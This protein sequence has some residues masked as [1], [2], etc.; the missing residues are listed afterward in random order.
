MRI[1][2]FLVTAG[3][4]AVFGSPVFAQQANPLADV[5]GTAQKLMQQA[6]PLNLQRPT[7]TPERPQG[8]Q[9]ATQPAQNAAGS[10]IIQ[11]TGPNDSR[12]S[13]G[14]FR[15]PYG[16]DVKPFDIR[17][18]SL[19]VSE[20]AVS[21][22]F[23]AETDAA[24]EQR[25]RLSGSNLDAARMAE[26]GIHTTY[27]VSNSDKGTA[28]ATISGD[29]G[30]KISFNRATMAAYKIET[31]VS[32]P[33]GQANAVIAKLVAKYGKQFEDRGITMVWGPHDFG[34]SAK[35]ERCPGEIQAFR[36]C[37]PMCLTA[38]V[39]DE[40]VA[41][42][43]RDVNGEEAAKNLIKQAEQKETETQMNRVKF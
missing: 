9:A 29:D 26:M 40:F 1:A 17:G 32:F 43:L 37:A 16:A 20:S 28:V 34:I 3:C 35:H 38:R 25:K 10:G 24:L 27:N 8:N 33:Y 15:Q 30:V 19:G 39:Y 31:Q 21:A 11:L 41:L 12:T 5:L 2:V 36:A 6:Q 18:Y 4:V 42:E 14:I 22:K 13:C 7:A 23:K